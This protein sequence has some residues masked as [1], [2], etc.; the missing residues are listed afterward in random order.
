[1][2]CSLF[3]KSSWANAGEDSVDDGLADAEE[4]PLVL[5]AEHQR[6]VVLL[7]HCTGGDRGKGNLCI[8]VMG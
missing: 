6:L 1:M 4:Q 7:S 5:R 3:G 8:N 2:R